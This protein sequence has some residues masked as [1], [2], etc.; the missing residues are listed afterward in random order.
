[1]KLMLL[2]MPTTQSP[3]T[4]A[5]AET[6]ERDGGAVQDA[7]QELERVGHEGDGDPQGHGDGR[8]QDLE[9][10][11]PASADLPAV[12][13]EAQG[14]GQQRAAQQG[15]ELVTS[16]SVTAPDVELREGSG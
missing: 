15:H 3:V 9:D 11:L 8:Q 13:D 12:V 7:A 10:E 1:M 16:D 2:I 4:S 14:R 5:G 6:G